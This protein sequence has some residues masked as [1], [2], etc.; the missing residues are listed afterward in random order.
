M[1][2]LLLAGLIFGPVTCLISQTITL[3]VRAFIDGRDQLIISQ[4]TLQWHHFDYAAVGR[5]AGTNAPTIISTTLNGS[6]VMSSVNWIPDWGSPPPDE[7][8]HEALSHV[9]SG[10]SPAL[11]AQDASV[12]LNVLAAR[13]S[14]ALVQFP[15]STNGYTTI[16]EFNDDPPAG[17]DWYEGVLTFV[18]V[19]EPT[20]LS[21]VGLGAV[22]LVLRRKS[23]G[24]VR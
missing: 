3:D 13:N 7:I 5:I 6:P 21:L 22:L 2:K 20:A 10:L 17:P 23:K 12:S 16:L 8:R 19:P 1:R 11:P 9:F 14:L 24:G 18:V 15:F 4:N